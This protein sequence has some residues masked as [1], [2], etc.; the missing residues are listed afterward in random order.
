MAV[1]VNCLIVTFNRLELL[2]EC[3]AAVQAQTYPVHKIIVINNA[4]SDGTKEYLDALPSGIF[5]PVHLERNTGGAGGFNAGLKESCRIGADWTW[6]MDDD[7]IPC[8][9]ALEKMIQSLQ[10]SEGKG[11][12]N[13]KFGFLCSTVLF[14]D[15]SPHKMNNFSPCDMQDYK[16]NHFMGD[17]IL[18]M[19][20]ASFV[21]C[22]IRYDAI[23][24]CGFPIADFFIWADDVEYTRR[25]T[26]AGFLGG[27]VPASFVVHK[28]KVN[29]TTS[30]VTVTPDLLWRFYYDKRNIMYLRKKEWDLLRFLF[31]FP[32]FLYQNCR[33]C[34]KRKDNRMRL[35]FIVLRGIFAGLFFNPRIE[36]LMP[37]EAA[38]P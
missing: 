28:T 2:K 4:S 3:I 31:H 18:L 12:V 30:L 1:K 34:L 17:G 8:P 13:G 27:V 32:F 19:R 14:T 11:K 23:A 6:C 9:D 7:T 37:P 36:T 25:I 29:Y 20:E 5:V 16:Y 33:D 22:L 38:E 10:S 24:K 15:G 35:L 21:S 26:K